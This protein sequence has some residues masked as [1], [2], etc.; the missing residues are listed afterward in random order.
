MSKN[1]KAQNHDG[2]ESVEEALTRTER[3]IEQ[4][5]K[6]LTIIILVILL[7]VGGYLSYKRFIL[8]PKEKEAQSEMY[9][10]ERYFEMDS[11]NLAL[12]GDGQ[13]LG[14]VE[15]VDKYAA[16]KSANLACYYAGISYL[17]LGEFED[18]INY[19]E[20]FDASDRLVSVVA[21]GAIGD[22]YIELDNLKKGISFYEKAASLNENEL[23]SPIYLMKAGLNY[24]LLGE[25][26]K[27]L[28]AYETIKKKFP[29]STEARDIE[30]YL[31][32]VKMKL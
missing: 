17:H 2:F 23:T 26:K 5:R 27:A 7:I 20:D 3:Y 4:N 18:A 19:L 15:I 6:S 24:E 12:E 1:N 25:N 11:F 9:M 32:A 10:A 21:L 22:A 8:E 28:K 13:Y 29:M 31:T 16:T 30:K 14:L